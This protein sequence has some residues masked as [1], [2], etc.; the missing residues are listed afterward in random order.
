MVKELIGKAVLVRDHMAGVH[1]G[2]LVAL[3]I[4]AGTV[5]LCDA[6]KLWRWQAAQGV[7]VHDVAVYGVHRADCRISAM[8]PWVA[9]RSLVEIMPMSD[10][11]LA[12]LGVP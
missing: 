2:T 10:A 9:M 4:A 8:V 6:R 7:S 1:I 11:A 12:T 3:D 5:E